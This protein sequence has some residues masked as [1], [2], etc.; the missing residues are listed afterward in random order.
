MSDRSEETDHIAALRQA[1]EAID[2]ALAAL[3]GSEEPTVAASREEPEWLSLGQ[4]AYRC[5]KCHPET[6][7][8]RAR[9]HG[10]GRRVGGQWMIDWK[11]VSAWLEVRPFDPIPQEDD[12]PEIVERCGKQS[13]AGD[14]DSATECE[15]QGDPK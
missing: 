7:A 11:R 4:A 9:A 10:L 1:R 3:D 15:P 13:D 8:R 5:G 12:M 2:R 14:D 6:M